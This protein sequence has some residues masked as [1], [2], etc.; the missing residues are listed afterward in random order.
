MKPN[1]IFFREEECFLKL[2]LVRE[3]GRAIIFDAFNS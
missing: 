1:Y 2:H 3:Y